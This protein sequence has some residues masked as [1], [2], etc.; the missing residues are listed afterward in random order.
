MPVQNS[1]DNLT[2]Y[3]AQIYDE[4]IAK[5]LPYYKS[6]HQEIINFIKAIPLEPKIWLDTGCGTGEFVKKAMC[7][8]PH[9]I[10]FLADP[11]CDMMAHA[12]N[13]LCSS[14]KIH[15]LECC[16]SEDLIWNYPNK[17]DIITAIQCHHY[18]DMP[19]RF[20]ATQTCFRIL[21]EQGVYIT[22]ENIRPFTEKGTEIVKNYVSNFQFSKGKTK[23]EVNT[24]ISRFD[25]KHFPITI[26]EH[27]KMLRTIGF[28]TVEMLW[29]SYMQAGLYCIK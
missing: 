4:N 19:G 17:P 16:T 20:K 23:S 22:F 3:C 2:P 28:S 29:Y 27:L 25:S 15:F 14:E 10:F 7:V 26:E 12:Q 24:Y 6:F 1:S 8:F 9:T 21:K 18:L 11:A 5:T 13:N